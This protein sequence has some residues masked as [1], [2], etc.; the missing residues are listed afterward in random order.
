MTEAIMVGTMR[1]LEAGTPKPDMLRGAVDTL[2][3]DDA[4]VDAITRATADE[5]NVKTR[6]ALATR[7]L[8][9]T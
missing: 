7:V 5:E 2:V 3:Q 8:A 4:F 6:L 9:S 1:R